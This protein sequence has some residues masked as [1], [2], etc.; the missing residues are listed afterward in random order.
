MHYFI[1]L[2]DDGLERLSELAAGPNATVAVQ[3][4]LPELAVAMC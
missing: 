1:E 2:G 3:G 4:C